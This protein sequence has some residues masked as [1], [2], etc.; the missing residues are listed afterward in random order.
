MVDKETVDNVQR[1]IG[2]LQSEVKTL[3]S[4]LTEVKSDLK[5]IRR[6]FDEL[7]GGTK[8]LMTAAAGIGGAIALVLNWLSAKH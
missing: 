4:T 7:K 8:L 5:E 3:N 6:S 1:N 2:Q